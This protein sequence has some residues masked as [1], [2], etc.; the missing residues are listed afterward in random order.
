[1]ITF[2]KSVVRSE[3]MEANVEEML[4]ARVD[5]ACP[6][7]VVNA[8]Q[9]AARQVVRLGSFVN[10]LTVYRH[11]YVDPRRI[12]DPIVLVMMHVTAVIV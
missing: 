8:Q 11:T 3:G 9:L 7:T 4:D 10:V 6:D 1:M 5:T 12:T 2:S